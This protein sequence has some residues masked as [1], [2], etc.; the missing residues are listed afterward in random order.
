MIDIERQ[1]ERLFELGPKSA[2][3]WM[4]NSLYHRRKTLLAHIAKAKR[5]YTKEPYVTATA[6]LT[7]ID[8][9]TVENLEDLI[10]AIEARKTR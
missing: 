5:A 7:E 6:L 9:A 8:R 10:T 2:V 4:L 3:P 1:I